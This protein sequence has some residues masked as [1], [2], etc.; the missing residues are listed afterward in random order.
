[1]AALLLWIEWLPFARMW[2][3]DYP[4]WQMPQW[5]LVL[6]RFLFKHIDYRNSALVL[7]VLL[8]VGSFALHRYEISSRPKGPST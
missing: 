5:F 7:A 4:G 1:M 2:F 3:S 8:A 6:G